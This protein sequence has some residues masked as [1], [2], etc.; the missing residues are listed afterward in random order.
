MKI[1]GHSHGADTRDLPTP[2]PGLFEDAFALEVDW[3]PVGSAGS[4]GTSRTHSLELDNADLA[5]FVSP[6]GLSAL[7]GVVAM[8]GL[9][10]AA[11][12][13]VGDTAGIGAT[14]GRVAIGLV[15]TAGGVLMAWLSRTPLQFDRR[16]GIFSRG[17]PTANP[18]VKV[19]APFQSCPLADIHALQILV[20]RASTRG[21]M[22]RPYLSY[23]LNLVLDDRTRVNV[24][25]HGDGEAVR[26]DAAVLGRFLERPVWDATQGR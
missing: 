1:R 15:I 24:L 17:R 18:L 10:I 8:V 6:L 26:K 16:S 21:S 22:S 2:D 14:L 3:T 7:G 23:E 25:D 9:V 5:R 20:K 11:F 12:A 4:S 13:L 19:L